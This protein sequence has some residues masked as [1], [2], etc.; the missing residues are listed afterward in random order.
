MDKFLCMV[1]WLYMCPYMPF[2]HKKHFITLICV[3]NTKIQSGP[4]IY[5]ST[6]KREHQ[7]IKKSKHACNIYVDIFSNRLF[8][9]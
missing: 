2:N 1:K 5:Y 7:A 9:G 3:I 8:F 4:V 6:Y